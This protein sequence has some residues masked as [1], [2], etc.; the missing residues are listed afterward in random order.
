MI[1]EAISK[2]EAALGV[3]ARRHDALW[4]LGN[5]YTS[6]G[7][8]STDAGSGGWGGVG[9]APTARRVGHCER[10]PFEPP[11]PPLPPPLS[12]P[13]PANGYF[14]KAG[15]C[16][17]RAVEQEPGNDSYR[18]ARTHT[19]CVCLCVERGGRGGGS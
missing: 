15:D 13:P 11:S 7:F 19:A 9:S 17:K 2:F 12:T 5:A 4:C 3:D 16:F 1:E 14:E 8:L 10:A 6:Q 18:H